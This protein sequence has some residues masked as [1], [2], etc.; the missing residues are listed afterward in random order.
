MGIFCLNSVPRN[1]NYATMQTSLLS[2][3]LLTVLVYSVR[4]DITCDECLEFGA[5]IQEVM[6]AQDS[7]TSQRDIM[8]YILCPMTEDPAGCYEHLD[9]AWPKIAAAIYPIFLEANAVCGAAGLWGAE[10]M[11]TTQEATCDQCTI[12]MYELAGYL[13]DRARVAEITEL[14]QGDGYCASEEDAAACSVAVGQL[15]PYALPVIS[16]IFYLRA[17]TFCCRYSTG[18]LCC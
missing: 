1:G 14:L 12:G 2:F 11:I 9:K 6:M 16:G 4:A 5:K 17:P 10:S 7:V 15:M 3:L 18:N 8:E 13:T